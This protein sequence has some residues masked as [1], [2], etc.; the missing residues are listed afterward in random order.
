MARIRVASTPAASVPLPPAGKATLFLDAD[1]LSF[2]AKYSDGTLLILNTTQEY[3]E[4][5][6]G[7]LFQ[8]SGSIDFTYDDNGNVAT[9]EVVEAGLDSGLI[10]ITPQGNLT[11]DNVQDG[12]Y[13]LQN[14]V[15]ANAQALQDHL[16][17]TTDSHD[18]T[19]I[20]Y[21][22][23]SSGLTA[24][25]VQNA[26]DEVEGRLDTQE[27]T[28][29][30][31]L[32]GDPS[33]H[34]ATE[35]DYE[36][37]DLD[38]KSIQ[39][40]SDTVE[41]AL[42]DLDDNKLARDGSQPMTGNLD[43]DGNNIVTGAG[44]VDGRDVSADGTKLDTIETNAKDD[45]LASEVP[46]DN[47]VSGLT[48]DDVQDA[49]DELDSRLDA[50]DS[51]FTDHIDGGPNKHDA[52]EIDY[53]RPDGNKVSI[54][55]S[56]DNVETA[57]TDLD[58][59][60][61]ARNGSQPMTGDLNM[62][63]N[64][65]ITGSGT[66]DGRDV[67]ADGTKLDTIETN[68]KDDQ[69]ASEVP[70]S[71]AGN[72]SSSNVQ[73]AVE[74]LDAEKQPLDGD[75]TAVSNLSG[76]GIVTRTAANN[77]TTRTITGTSGQVDVTNGDGVSGNP[78]ISLPNVGPGAGTVGQADSSVTITT[79]VKG[80]VTARTA[81]L[82]N[83]VSSQV[84]NFAATVRSTLLTGYTVGASTAILATDTVLQAFGKVQAQLNTLFNRNINTGTGLQGG[85]NLTADR[86][87]SLT[88][89]GVSA[90]T[91]GNGTNVGTFTVDAQGRLTSAVNTPV[92][93][94]RHHTF[95]E[96]LGQSQTNSTT[97]QTKLTL[98]TPN[99][100]AGTYRIG[101]YYNW[102]L[103]SIADDFEA[104]LLQDGATN[105][106]EHRQEPQDSG[107]DQAFTNGGF[108]YR[109][110]TAGVH[111]FTLQYRTDD[112]A[113]TAYIRNVRLEIWRVQ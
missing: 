64:D 30:D 47:T 48:A 83:I 62:D 22:N 112:G 28:L 97:F 13:E 81:Q 7:N 31:H 92:T 43:M 42:S 16:D 75:L 73:A 76:T 95:A 68:A 23:A 80:R 17:N 108:V 49:I 99:L 11:S 55:A 26:V 70:F 79:D 77:M 53:E 71:P 107:T 20:S 72:I 9:M 69:L 51:D 14:N 1:D 35:I 8:D 100:S 113:V 98:T 87:L 50:A 66:V 32:D 18:A 82:I 93:F 33:K 37:A 44:L 84:S 91:Y 10:P 89:T 78:T 5:V 103:D 12:L 101:F 56:S 19:A 15:D 96:S 38:K 25:D 54:Q 74:E 110:L 21:D 104:R 59:N 105:I 27:S 41:S 63:G 58:D 36:R 86:T 85:G 29:A 52:T 57:L 111:T 102:S 61:L 46:Y 4:D 94:G 2:K 60:K 24:T 40:A 90:A 106:M 34:D 39:A 3:V 6:V 67:S 88:N 65:I 109:T 45:Q